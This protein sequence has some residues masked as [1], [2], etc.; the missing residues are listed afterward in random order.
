MKTQ[1]ETVLQLHGLIGNDTLRSATQLDRQAC[2]KTLTANK[3]K[4]ICLMNT[5]RFIAD[6]CKLAH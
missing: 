3:E 4:Y 6:I 1:P 2:G 5:S